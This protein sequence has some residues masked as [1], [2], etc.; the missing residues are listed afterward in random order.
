MTLITI[1]EEYELLP[2]NY[3][4]TMITCCVV[5]INGRAVKARGLSFCRV[6]RFSTR[7]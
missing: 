6:H 4:N 5:G 1:T 3:I 7:P 2:Y